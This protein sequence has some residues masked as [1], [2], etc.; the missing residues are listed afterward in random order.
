MNRKLLRVNLP[1]EFAIC[2]RVEDIFD[3][4]D[5]GWL[6]ELVPRLNFL[7]FCVFGGLCGIT[8]VAPIRR[9][10][11]NKIYNY[12]LVLSPLNSNL[13][14]SNLNNSFSNFANLFCVAFMEKICQNLVWILRSFEISHFELRGLLLIN[15]ELKRFHIWG[16]FRNQ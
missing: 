16:K 4:V 6:S 14:F 8:S 12:R 11:C 7:R 15:Y 1:S 13:L 3:S 2:R 10:V 5:G 9:F